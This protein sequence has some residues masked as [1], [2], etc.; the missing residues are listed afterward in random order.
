M[1][2][3][4]YISLVLAIATLPFTVTAIPGNRPSVSSSVSAAAQKTPPASTAA[5]DFD[6]RGVIQHALPEAKAATLGVPAQRSALDSLRTSVKGLTVRWSALTQAPSRVY[7]ISQPLTGSSSS[8][9][10]DIATA[11]LMQSL[12]LLNLSP[13]DVSEIRF[14][15]EYVTRHN[16]ISH[17]SIQQ[18]VNGADVFGAIINIDIDRDGRVLNLSGEMM[19]NIHASANTRTPVISSD[20]AIKKAAESAGVKVIRKAQAAGLVYFPMSLGNAL[21]AWD[22]SVGDAQTPNLYRTVV[23]SASGAVLWRQNLT[24]YNHV[25]AHGLVYTSDS[26]N[27]DTPTGTSTGIVSRADRPFNGLEFF[28]HADSHADWWNGS[29]QP[30]RNTTISNNVS[31]QEDRNGNDSGGF[32]PTAAAG[33]NY[34]FAVDLTMDPSTYQSAAITNLF[35]WCNRI[36]DIYYSLGFDEASGNF[37]VSNFGL[38]GSG[39]DP[40]QA[41]GQDDRDGGELCNANFSTPGDGSSPRMQMF[42]CDN[43]SPERDADFENLI[44]IHEYTHGLSNRLISG[45][46][47]A[48][49]GG[50]GEGWGDFMGLALTSES[51]DNLS[52][53]YPRGQWFYNMVNGNRRQPYSTNQSVYTFTYGDI[54]LNSEVHAVGEIW[55]NTLWIARANLVG[56]YG[57][58]TGGQTI[59]QL[60]VDGMKMAPPNPDFLD[61]RDAILMADL[62]DNGGV[63]QCLLWKAFATMGL[64]F[65]AA[66]TGSSDTSPV[67]AFDLPPTCCTAITCPPNITTSNDPNQCGAV[68]SFSAPVPQGSCGTITC[69][70]VSGS[71]FPKG[72][73]IVTCTSSEG[74]SC[75]FNVTVNDTQ[76]P[77]I[78]CPSDITAVTPRP[79]DACAVV[80][81]TVTGAD[82]CPGVTVVCTTPTGACFPR[83][84][85]MVTCTA[86]DTSGNTANC[87]FKVTVFD[88]RLQDDSISAKVILWNSLTGEYRFCCGGTLYSAPTSTVMRQG[89]IF[90]LEDRNSPRNVKVIG[91]CDAGVNSGTASVQSLA[92]KIICSVT[93]REIRNDTTLCQ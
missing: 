8:P 15:R 25:P 73:T 59:L 28:A 10:R 70:P 64:G 67:E 37:Q 41:D 51:G 91:R 77:S 19:P 81:Y 92:N 6:I 63:N 61:A 3:L 88:V 55:C 79:G 39:G 72:T 13:Q 14:S 31:A 47:G 65:S 35:Y 5:P 48:Q 43:S 40:V 90:T 38:G 42:Q 89:N 2:R 87:S 24:Q 44:I 12:A 45:L 46:A 30:D 75:S 54:S 17:T 26:P 11:F 34:T 1:R 29:G 9:A 16:G 76:P 71:F 23:D 27:P 33:E 68:V 58:A 78:T 80:N 62:M 93:D 82:N 57:F 50:M 86:T 4:L 74:P 60:V 83:G 53:N 66:T 20:A 56:K 84:T 52:L 22:V 36:H 85:T 49:G 18:Q 7:S 32:R 21:L 69:S